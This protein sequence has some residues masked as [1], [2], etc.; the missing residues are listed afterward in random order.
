MAACSA[1]SSDEPGGFQNTGGF[2][3]T[4]GFGGMPPGGG[5]AGNTPVGGGGTPPLGGAGSLNFSGSTSTGSSKGSGGESANC[6]TTSKPEEIIEYSPVGIFIMQDRSSSMITGFPPPASPQGW[7]NSSTAITAFVNDAASKGLR[8][9]LGSFPPMTGMAECATGANCGAPIVPMAELPGNAQAMVTG[10]TS[11]RPPD[12]GLLLTPIECGLR[13][14]VEQCKQF[15][16]ANNGMPC[17]AVLVTDGN[18]TE[19][20]LD[21]NVLMQIVRDAAAAG[22]KTFV[23]G[24]P[25]AS[26]QG[27][28]QVAAAGGTNKAIDVGAGSAGFVA[29]LNTIRT[30]IS[31]GTK[32]ECEWAIPEPPSGQEFNKEKVNLTFTPK[33]GAPTDFGYVDSEAACANATNA[34]HFDNNA[35]P[36]RILACPGACDVLKN[37]SGAQMDVK[38]GCARI[39]AVIQ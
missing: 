37:A 35:E 14:M 17:A 7:D 27:L 4:G 3:A 20:S 19:C 2:L 12:L 22:V 5:G 30:A 34:W 10:M 11:A 29:A 21:V 28:D 26:I 6:G 39:P 31:I 9:G 18:P 8:V 13:G 15:T 36:K 33:G 23:I 32:L 1:S 25:G 16:A 24:L 38:F